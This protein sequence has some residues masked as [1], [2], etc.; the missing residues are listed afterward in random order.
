MS[1]PYALLASQE[2]SYVTGGSVRR[3][4]RVGDFT[5]IF[6]GYLQGS[7]DRACAGCHASGSAFHNLS[8]EQEVCQFIVG[9]RQTAVIIRFPREG[10][11]SIDEFARCTYQSSDRQFRNAPSMGPVHHSRTARIDGAPVLP[12]MT[13]TF[14]SA[15]TSRLEKS[16]RT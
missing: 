16:L 4:R 9:A 2:S 10:I 14:R 15:S 11:S 13:L 8:G 7:I 3:N 1:P 6:S 12:S 5:S